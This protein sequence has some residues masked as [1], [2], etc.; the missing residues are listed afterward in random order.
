MPTDGQNLNPDFV[1]A[2]DPEGRISGEGVPALS[3]ENL[4]VLLKSKP[5]AHKIAGLIVCAAPMRDGGVLLHCYKRLPKG[6]KLA[7]A[8]DHARRAAEE[9]PAR[10]TVAPKGGATDLNKPLSALSKIP[11][12]KRLSML[13]QALSDHGISCVIG[14]L[15][16]TEGKIGDAGYLHSKIE[17]SHD[18]I[19]RSVQQALNGE[20]N[21]EEIN[22]LANSLGGKTIE[23]ILSEGGSRGVAIV[24]LD[25]DLTE[26]ELLQ[27]NIALFTLLHPKPYRAL[28]S[29]TKLM[30]RVT[31]GIGAVAALY[32]LFPAPIYVNNFAT[33]QP[34]SAQNI[35]LPF[36][37][38]I[39]NVSVRAGDLV[40]QGDALITLRAPDIQDALSEQNY[41]KELEVINAQEALE[42]GNLVEFQLAEKRK[43][44]AELRAAQLQSRNDLLSI[45][46]ASNGRV[47]FVQSQS[48]KG[49]FLAEGSPVISLQN[50]AT[51]DL[52]IEVKPADAARVKIGQVGRVN[53]RSIGGRRYGFEIVTVPIQ[54]QNPTGTG[55]VLQTKARL[56]DEDQTKLI[57]GLT[58]Y[59]KIETG[60]APR[61]VGITRPFRDYLR[62]MLWKYLGIAF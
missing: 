57:P 60:R 15:A 17:Q 49:M 53:F 42:Q 41:A 45:T 46:A 31:A 54:I 18:A 14:A 11:S 26:L 58:G 27:S 19:L 13:P 36:G 12:A 39:E 16:I 2:I 43:E 4:N 59:A 48:D 6:A 55:V 25:P 37:A 23:I 34:T 29:S 35:A 62:V 22:L 24:A 33:T 44:L 5:T 8:I 51:F 52:L 56:V 28:T 20:G 21:N 10:K 30:K 1:G 3:P 47:V 40:K 38:F 7:D 61:V 32:L 50:E 9:S